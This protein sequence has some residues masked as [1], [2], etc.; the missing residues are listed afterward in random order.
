MEPIT[1]TSRYVEVHGQEPDLNQTGD[2]HWCTKP[3]DQW[4]GSEAIH[5]GQ[6]YGWSVAMLDRLIT[7]YLLPDSTPPVRE[8]ATPVVNPETG[9]AKYPWMM[10]DGRPVDSN[11]YVVSE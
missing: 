6:R 9:E 4:L 5:K 2:W 1:D 11:G 10:P 3:D 7:W 8:R